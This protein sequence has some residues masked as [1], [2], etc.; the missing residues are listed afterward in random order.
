M[1]EEEKSM[2]EEENKNKTELL[3]KRNKFKRKEMKEKTK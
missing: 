2:S 3:Y 1:E